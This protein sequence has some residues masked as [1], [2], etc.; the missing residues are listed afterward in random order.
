MSPGVGGG[1]TGDKL[2]R[3]SGLHGTRSMC[4]YGKLREQRGWWGGGGGG[5]E[6]CTSFSEKADFMERGICVV[7]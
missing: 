2:R 4:G 1:G 7:T 6:R 5:G 3:E